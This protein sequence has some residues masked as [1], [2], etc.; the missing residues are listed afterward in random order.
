MSGKSA[1]PSQ[2]PRQPQ[3]SISRFAS[4]APNSAKRPLPESTRPSAR[5]RWRSNSALTIRV[6]TVGTVPLPS[7]AATNISAHQVQGAGCVSASA[8]TPIAPAGMP[9]K[10]TARAPCR[11]QSAPTVLLVSRMPS[12]K[13]RVPAWNAPS[14][15][16]NSRVMGPANTPRT[17]AGIAEIP[18]ITPEP[19]ASSAG[20]WRVSSFCMPGRC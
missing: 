6:Q 3:A 5:P 1:S 16:P 14:D 18:S 4:G 9:T 7:S 11:S 13:T 15:Q 8:A 20:Q 12:V 17:N 10:A 19:A 2:A